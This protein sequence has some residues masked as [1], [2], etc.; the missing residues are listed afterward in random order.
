M[1]FLLHCFFRQINWQL[2]IY[3]NNI[4]ELVHPTAC[5]IFQSSP[6]GDIYI[7]IYIYTYIYLLQLCCYCSEYFWNAV[8]GAAFRASLWNTQLK[9]TLLSIIFQKVMYTIYISYTK[10]ISY[11]IYINHIHLI[12]QNIVILL[13]KPFP[14]PPPEPFLRLDPRLSPPSPP[15]PASQK[16]CSVEKYWP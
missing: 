12:N 13:L 16:T 11:I 7:Y 3:F 15:N 5:C 2:N 8:F 10:Y 6:L 1:F 14:K 4:P 9:V